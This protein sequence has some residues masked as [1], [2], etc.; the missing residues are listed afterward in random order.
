M[1][2]G[3]SK[4]KSGATR[5]NEPILPS[6]PNEPNVTRAKRIGTRSRSWGEFSLPPSR[7][8]TNLTRLV[9]HRSAR[10]WLAEEPCIRTERSRAGCIPLPVP[11]AKLGPGER[12]KSFLPSRSHMKF[13]A[14]VATAVGAFATGAFAV[15]AFAI[16][17]LAIGGSLFAPSPPKK[18]RLNRSG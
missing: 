6:A 8:Q 17:A 18:P 1:E 4:T 3:V 16:G 7:Y 11:P 9:F 14:G 13:R 15:G 2:S 5:K 10:S 12:M